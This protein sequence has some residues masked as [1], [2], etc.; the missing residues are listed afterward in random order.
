MAWGLVRALMQRIQEARGVAAGHSFG[1]A[2]TVLIQ[3]II[4]ELFTLVSEAQ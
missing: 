1:A 3:F 2:A 4:F